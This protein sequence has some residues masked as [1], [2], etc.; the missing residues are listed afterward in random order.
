MPKCT[1]CGEEVAKGTLKIFVYTSGKIANF[2]GRKCQKNLIKL[3]RKPL[4]TKWTNY[5][6]QEHKKG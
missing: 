5:Y 4:E 3:G 1:F 2:C 6:R